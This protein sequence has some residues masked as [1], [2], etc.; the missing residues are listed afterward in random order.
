MFEELCSLGKAKDKYIPQ[1]YLNLHKDLLLPLFDSL[2]KGDGSRIKRVDRNTEKLNYYTISKRLADNVQELAQKVGLKASIF[3]RGTSNGFIRGRE[4]KGR[5]E[6]YQV[7][8]GFKQVA[9]LINLEKKI[10]KYNSVAYCVTTPYHTLYVRRNGVASWCGNS[11]V[12]GATAD[13]TNCRIIATTPGDKPS[14]AKRLRFGKDGEKIKVITLTYDLDPRKSKKWLDEQRERRSTEDFNREI[15]VN[16]ETSITGRVYPELESA[17]YGNFPFLVNEQLYCSWDFGLDGTSISFW[18]QNPKNGKWRLVDSYTNDNQTIQFFFPFFGKPVDSKFQYNDDDLKAINYISQYPKAVHFGDPDVRKRSYVA[19]TT[20]RLELEKVGIYVNTITKNDFAYRRDKTKF[21][22][23]KGIE[24]NANPRNDYFFE[25]IKSYRYPQRAEDSQ[26]TQP[27]SLP[28][29]DWCLAGETKIRTLNGWIPIKDLVGEEFW[30][31]S[32]SHERKRMIPKKVTKCWE[33]NPKA[34]TMLVGLDDGHELRCTPNHPFLLRNGKYK[35]AQY[36]KKGDSL[37]P[38][39]EKNDGGYVDILFPDGTHG[40]EHRIVYD[41]VFGIKDQDN[42]I[43]HKDNIK[44]HN[45]PENLQEMTGQEHTSKTFKG[46]ANGQRSW[47]VSKYQPYSHRGLIYK[48]CRGCEKEFLTDHK[49]FFCKSICK[50][51]FVR[52]KLRD[53]ARNNEEYRAL[54]RLVNIEYEKRHAR[55]CADCGVLISR[56]S[57]RCRACNGNYR[58]KINHKVRFIKK[59]WKEIPVYDME[60]PDT[61]NFVAEGVFTHNTS[62]PATS[63]E[64]FFINIDSFTQMSQEAPSWADS[65]GGWFTSRLKAIGRGRRRGG[66]LHG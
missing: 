30:V 54:A 41:E 20:T 65:K 52:K 35:E 12:W 40:P 3:N 61:H 2:V 21:Y 25:A 62:H 15:M 13:T 39:Y 17:A 50:K 46:V 22:L 16:W 59:D 58:L 48:N 7:C 19:D 28:V 1:R 51:D 29:H 55:K 26:A 47:E 66:E 38:F 63:M 45:S 53:R 18:Q 8:F 49:H 27:I 43:D 9:H 32:Y 23:Q 57:I 10:V 11:A 60:V 33:T 31:W 4:V 64:Y 44:F 36:L 14:K 6:I 56:K 42:H 5:Y 34:K 37:M 24:I